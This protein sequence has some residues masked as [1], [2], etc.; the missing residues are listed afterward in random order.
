MI[1]TVYRRD[2]RL[3]PVPDDDQHYGD[4]I[5]AYRGVFATGD[6][7]L[8]VGYWDFKG[9]QRTRGQQE[10]YEEVV[11]VTEGAV[12]IECDGVVAD[13]RA[14]DTIVYECPVGAK[15]IYAPDGFKGVYVIRYRSTAK[16]PG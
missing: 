14:G 15:R 6:G 9:E 13:L 2:V 12:H 8:H 16:K 5:S 1:H 11:I 4:A 3:D 7:V 10:G